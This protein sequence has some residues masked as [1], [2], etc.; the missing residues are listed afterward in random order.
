MTSLILAIGGIGVFLLG[1]VILTEGLKSLTGARLSQFLVS[2]THSPASGA[3]TGAATTAVLQSSSAT[4]VA[5]VGFVGAGLLSFPQALGIIFG[6][7]LGTTIT[8]WMVA[9]LGFKLQLGSLLLPLIFVGIMLR[10]F[11]RGNLSYFGYALAGFG[12]IFVGIDLLQQAAADT[13][14]IRADMLPA[15]S[16]SGRLQLL[17]LGIIAT[18][19][20]QSSSAGVAATLVMMNSGVIGFEQAAALVIGMDVG[21]TVTA[22]MATVGGSVGS[23]RTGFSHVIYNLMTAVVAFLLI[24][25][26][27]LAWQSLAPLQLETNAEI[28]LVAFHSSFNLLGVILVLPF[29]GRFAALIEHLLPETQPQYVKSLDRALL[30][31]PAVAIVAVARII[32]TE[33]LTLMVN[34]NLILEQQAQ[35]I[36]ADLDQLQTILDATHAFLDLI[37]ISNPRQQESRQLLALIHAFDHMQRLHERCDEDLQRALTASHNPNLRQVETILDDNIDDIVTAV[38]GHQWQR[39]VAISQD[40]YQ[41]VKDMEGPQRDLIYQAVARGEIEVPEATDCAEALRWLTRVSRHIARICYYLQ[42]VNSDKSI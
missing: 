22:A 35:R 6:A 42:Q 12:L 14:L 5:A 25:P 29:A 32:E 4:T 20:T 27:T 41:Q 1:M 16:L 11:A 18:V 28:V 7:N 8:G 39:A 15:D 33:F 23:R 9:L 24:T 38:R 40:N 17:A 31:E 19:I 36:R 21:T 10:L 26:F 37:H 13:N 34:I 2:A 30:K 3:A